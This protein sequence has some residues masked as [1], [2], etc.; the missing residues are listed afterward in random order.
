MIYRI[1]G[2]EGWDRDWE[3]LT[4]DLPEEDRHRAMEHYRSEWPQRQL[5][6]AY[7]QVDGSES[8]T[9]IFTEYDKTKGRG[10]EGTGSQDCGTY[11]HDCGT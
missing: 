10:D 6:K 5:R 8:E 11:P 4:P 2:R 1:Y 7:T 3:R 9:I